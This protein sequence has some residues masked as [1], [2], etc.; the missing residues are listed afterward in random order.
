MPKSPF[1]R[2]HILHQKQALVVSSSMRYSGTQR[3]S[4]HILCKPNSNSQW[5]VNYYVP[6]RRNKIHILTIMT[7]LRVLVLHSSAAAGS[8]SRHYHLHVGQMAYV[9]LLLCTRTLYCSLF[10]QLCFT[11]NHQSTEQNP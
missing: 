8:H 7:L 11:K 4:R 2:A 3:N 6:A 1:I 5:W 10:V 9:C